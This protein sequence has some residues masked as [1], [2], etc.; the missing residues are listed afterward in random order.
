MHK[1]TESRERGEV[2]YADT[3]IC[4]TTATH[5][6]IKIV[7]DIVWVLLWKAKALIWKLLNLETE[8]SPELG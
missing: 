4:L 3:V 7:T 2:G 6:P 1:N 5:S 8:I